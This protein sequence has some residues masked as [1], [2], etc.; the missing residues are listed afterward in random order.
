MLSMKQYDAFV[1][2]NIVLLIRLLRETQMIP[3]MKSEYNINGG[4]FGGF[5]KD[6]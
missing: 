4:V 1:C 6:D 3:R 5:E 2:G